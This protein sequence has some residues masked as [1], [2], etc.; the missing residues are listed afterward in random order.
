MSQTSELHTK[1]NASLTFPGHQT[2]IAKPLQ[3]SDQEVAYETCQSDPG[4]SVHGGE[5]PA[6]KALLP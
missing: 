4:V 2:A 1:S 3:L 5:T 6:R